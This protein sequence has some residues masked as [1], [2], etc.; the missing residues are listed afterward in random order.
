MAIGDAIRKYQ[1]QKAA[2]ATDEEAAESQP[3]KKDEQPTMAAVLAKMAE[4]IEKVSSTKTDATKDAA[5]RQIELIEQ[6]ITKTHPEN[7]DHPGISV[8]NPDGDVAHPKPD[9]KCKFYWVGYDMRP[10][11]LTR[12]E[13]E[14]LNRLTPGEYR[15]TKS[16]G[17]GIPFRVEGKKSDKLDD[18][19][20][21]QLESISIWFSCKNEARHN[22]MSMV[23]Y[24]Q[25][26]LGDKIPT[27]AEMM[28]ELTRIKKELATA[29]A[30]V[31]GVV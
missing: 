11:T 24:L 6:L 15:V 25:Q 30:G 17:V 29:R 10:E 16:D 4:L 20:V 19:G 26:V 3:A 14:L 2:E 8:F 21:S 22:H 9:L 28:K 5:Y 13:I 7:V 18:Q 12:Q 23:S 31:V 27:V 1:E